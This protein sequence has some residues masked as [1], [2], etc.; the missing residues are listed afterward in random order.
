MKKNLL[1]VLALCIAGGVFAQEYTIFLG[2][3]LRGFITVQKDSGGKITITPSISS[4]GS[5]WIGNAICPILP[6]EGDGF[7]TYDTKSN[8]F[9][10]SKTIASIVIDGNTTT[11]TRTDGNWH[12]IVNDGNTTTETWSDGRWYRTVTEGNRITYTSSFGAEEITVLEG[13]TLTKTHLHGPLS[14]H[15]RWQKIVVSENTMTETDSSGSWARAVISGNTT[16]ITTSSN[17]R[18]YEEVIRGNTRTF[19]NSHDARYQYSE[20]VAGNTIT[21]TSLDGRRR[22]VI[23]RQGNDIFLTLTGSSYG[24]EDIGVPVK[25]QVQSTINGIRSGRLKDGQFYELINYGR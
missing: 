8:G 17:N 10:V 16:T 15:I 20:V 14:N 25:D 23:D 13:N 22:E 7:R 21:L 4:D 9:R 1:L 11:E 3:T 2:G 5:V 12:K 18:G 19:A 24:F 6:G